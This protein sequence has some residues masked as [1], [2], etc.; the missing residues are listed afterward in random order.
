MI[1]KKVGFITKL[2]GR[3]NEI[4]RDDLVSGIRVGAELEEVYHVEKHNA[5]EAEGR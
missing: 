2:A 1:Y 3:I 5:K 4:S